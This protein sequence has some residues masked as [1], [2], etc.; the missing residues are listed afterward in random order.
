MSKKSAPKATASISAL[1][2]ATGKNRATVAST[3]AKAGLEPVREGPKEKL[4][5]E[6]DA[7]RVLS[8]AASNAGGALTEARRKKTSAEAARIVLKL[9]KERGDLVAISDVREY[10]FNFVKAMH[11]RFTRYAREARRRL[12]LK[13]DQARAMETDIAI[14]FDDLK[15]DHP[16]I[17]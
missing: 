14:I 11:Q 10:A 2:R 3:L 5:D 1:A 13:P 6:R 15:R 12:K 8:S 9:Q 7:S 17:F 16:N 4:F